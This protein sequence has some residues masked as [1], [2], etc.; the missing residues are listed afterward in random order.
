ML[1]NFLKERFHLVF[2]H[3]TQSRPGY[4]LVVAGGGPK[5]HPFVPPAEPAPAVF[6]TD[7]NGFPQLGSTGNGVAFTMSTSGRPEPI[8]LCFRDTITTFC[9]ALGSDINAS[10]G[11]PVGGPVPRVLDKTGLTGVYEFTLEFAGV[12]VAPGA[13]P[14]GNPNDMLTASDPADSAP[15][16]F[17]AVEKQ[18]GLKLQKLKEV[19][20]DV[21]IIEKADKIPTEN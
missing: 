6:K 10:N 12:M 4:E 19:P 1:Q 5:I 20:V 7:R 3:E 8:R 11:I 15:N 14:Q 18:L 16:I 21:F 2:H 13:V 9:R 17:T